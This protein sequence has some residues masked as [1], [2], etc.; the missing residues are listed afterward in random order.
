MSQWKKLV[1]E[2]THRAEDKFDSLK[3]Q[4]GTRLGRDDGDRLVIIP[5]R[6]YGTAQ[7]LYLKGRVLEDEGISSPSAEDSTLRNLLNTYK[8]FESDEIAGALVMCRFQGVEQKVMSDEEGF[9]E[10][11]IQ[12][13]EPLPTDRLWHEVELE[14]LSPMR[15]GDPPVQATGY[16]LVPPPSA[17]F[18]VISDMDDTVVYTNAS[19]LLEMGRIVFMGNA[20]TR[21]PFEGVAAF[22]QALQAGTQGF[23]PIFYVSSS[24]WNLYDLLA[25]FLQIQQIPSGPLMLRDW[26][27]SENE[28]LPTKHGPHKISAIRQILDT[29]PQLPFILIGDSGQEDPEIYHDIVQQYPNRILA[30]YIR[31]VTTKA[32]RADTILALASDVA[33]AGSSLILANDTLEAATH[34][35]AQGWI[36]PDV[37]LQIQAQ[38]K[39]DDK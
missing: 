22:Y 15:E 38:K 37:L 25:E 10:L 13:I 18:G 32:K 36:S 6:G 8:R 28:F 7:R 1:T 29:Y 17:Q 3:K 19:N 31:N 14:L 9:F 21:I 2:V 35:A 33:K 16:V 39:I 12:P 5:Y 20:R 34:A 4:L 27:I 24:P 23:N 11:C 30:V 26:G